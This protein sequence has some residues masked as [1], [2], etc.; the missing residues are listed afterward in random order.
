MS[1]CL[2]LC[3]R[4]CLSVRK[5]YKNSEVRGN[6]HATISWSLSVTNTTWLNTAEECSA[7]TLSGARLSPRKCGA[8]TLYIQ[9]QFTRHVRGRRRLAPPEALLDRMGRWG[10][11]STLPVGL[12]GLS[13]RLPAVSGCWDLSAGQLLLLEWSMK[14]LHYSPEEHG[15]VW[16]YTRWWTGCSLNFT[17]WHVHGAVLGLERS[18]LTSVVVILVRLYWYKFIKVGGVSDFDTVGSRW[19]ERSMSGVLKCTLH[20][21]EIGFYMGVVKGLDYW[22]PPGVLARTSRLEKRWSWSRVYLL[23]HTRIYGSLRAGPT[24]SFE[25]GRLRHGVKW[26][27]KATSCAKARGL[28]RAQLSWYT[29]TLVVRLTKGVQPP[30]AS[31]W[32]EVNCSVDRLLLRVKLI[33]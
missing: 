10:A 27:M 23:T 20:S 5:E 29:R 12:P 33:L 4:T 21:R 30:S 26:F 11:S 31:L 19:V 17:T 6:A 28:L 18:R 9:S 1:L 2:F 13:A 24:L 16:P 15:T 8:R 3:Q 14:S 22:C 32:E 7:Q 25:A